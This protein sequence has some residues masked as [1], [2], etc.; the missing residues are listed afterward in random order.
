MRGI[1]CKL[2]RKRC[3][4]V[5]SCTKHFLRSNE[6]RGEGGKKGIIS[7]RGR[8]KLAP[9]PLPVSSIPPVIT[10]NVFPLTNP[11]PFI[12]HAFQF[13]PRFDP[14][15]RNDLAPISA[16]IDAQCISNLS[17]SRFFLKGIL[18]PNYEIGRSP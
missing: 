3:S 8:L 2:N 13:S 12:P 6:S 4:A 11:A 9:C 18:L 16:S 17:L 7:G 10:S 1:Q 15:F 14:P 5:S